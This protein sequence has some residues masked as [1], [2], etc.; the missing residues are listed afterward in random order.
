MIRRR[1]GLVAAAALGLAAVA[2]NAVGA[3]GAVVSGGAGVVALAIGEY[4]P[5][6]PAASAA[7]T[8]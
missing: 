8:R 7:R 5:R 3:L 2:V 6:L 4:G 1:G